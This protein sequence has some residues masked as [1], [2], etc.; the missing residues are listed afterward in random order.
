M[1]ATQA[2]HTAGGILALVGLGA[3]VLRILA[4]IPTNGPPGSVSGTLILVAI[5]GVGVAELLGGSAVLGRIA[6]GA[7]H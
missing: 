1:V 3:V 4:L 5:L 7:R 6:A 2:V